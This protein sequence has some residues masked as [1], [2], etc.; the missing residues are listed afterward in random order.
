MKSKV[1]ISVVLTICLSINTAIAQSNANDGK[2]SS[3]LRSSE[4][5]KP[6]KLQL[7]S[8]ISR[9]GENKFIYYWN[10]DKNKITEEVF[11][12][13]GNRK[14]PTNKT[15][16][17]YDN[18]GLIQVEFK[19]KWKEDLKQY[20]P[21]TTM[22]G[23]K[24]EYIYDINGN[25]SFQYQYYWSLDKESFLPY[26]KEEFKYNKQGNKTARLWYTWNSKLE[27]F[28][29]SY[30]TEYQYN[31]A[32]NII[33][34]KWYD[35]ASYNKDYRN[36]F[37]LRSKTTFTYS[38]LLDKQY[39]KSYS[40]D[41]EAQDMLLSS[42]EEVRYIFKNTKKFSLKY[43]TWEDGVIKNKF[44]YQRVMYSPS[45][46]KLSKN[47]ISTARISSNREYRYDNYGICIT[48]N[49]YSLNKVT[50]A[51]YKSNTR[52]RTILVDDE[53]SLIYQYTDSDYDLDFYNWEIDK[54]WVEYYSKVEK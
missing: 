5:I 35:Y 54:E 4:T 17:I 2:T 47:D 40:W 7:D 37:F 30:R 11:Q 31:E 8:L 10:Y 6:F 32:G 46:I 20:Q 1:K 45:F 3:N 21:S 26:D 28:D 12:I 53:K 16:S 23:S 48:Y 14:K 41:A 38:T 50:N 52:I 22:N 25:N 43:H 19:Y 29:L 44:D 42:K 34:T 51:N 49:K 24:T 18:R 15:E 13:V 39:S 33:E 27:K 36:E 9:N